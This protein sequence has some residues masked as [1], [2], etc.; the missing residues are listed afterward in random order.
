MGGQMAFGSRA[1]NA[2]MGNKSER[3]A[4]ELK[5]RQLETSDGDGAGVS[6]YASSAV[7]GS[8]RTQGREDQSDVSHQS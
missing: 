8:D 6:R 7:K 4:Q 1:K 3:V 2:R 5:S